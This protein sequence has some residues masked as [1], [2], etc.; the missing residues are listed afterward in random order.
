VQ[1]FLPVWLQK[2]FGDWTIYGG[3]GYGLNSY[4]P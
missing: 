3:G 4:P 1:A 2:S